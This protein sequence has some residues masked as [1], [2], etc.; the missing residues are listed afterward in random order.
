M[1]KNFLALVLG[2]V[3]TASLIAGC[4][5]KTSSG[6]SSASSSAAADAG[7]TSV[8]EAAGEMVEGGEFIKGVSTEAPGFD[9]FTTQTADARSIF[10]N[11]YEGLMATEPDGSFSMFILTSL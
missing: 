3:M 2:A 8:T 11:I 4:G 9:P 6:G 10:F 7:S 5:G 1:K